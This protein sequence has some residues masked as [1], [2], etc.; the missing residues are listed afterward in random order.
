MARAKNPRF[1]QEPKGKT[2]PKT[3]VSRPAVAAPPK[4]ITAVE[5][6]NTGLALLQQGKNEKALVLLLQSLQ[7]DPVQATLHHEVRP[8]IL[9]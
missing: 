1:G 4:G 8:D 3:T 6:K 2:H 5:L 7:L 9:L